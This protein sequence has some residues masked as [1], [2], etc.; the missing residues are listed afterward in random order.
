MQL[1]IIAI[2]TVLFI[3]SAGTGLDRGIK[4]LSNANLFLAIILF[5]SFFIS[6]SY[7]IP[8]GFIH[9]DVRGICSEF[10]VYGI[11]SRSF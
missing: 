11:A 5:I 9:Y 4:Y 8:V 1:I 10:I 3:L 6:W 2:V 7:R